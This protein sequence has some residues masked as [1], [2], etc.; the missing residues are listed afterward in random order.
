MDSRKFSFH[1]VKSA[2][3]WLRPLV[4]HKSNRFTR[5]NFSHF[6]FYFT[7]LGANS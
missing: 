5:V 7:L 2:L 1:S 4:K 6:T 3:L